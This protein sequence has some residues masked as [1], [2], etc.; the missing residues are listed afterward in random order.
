LRWD[1]D[2][3]DGPH[4]NEEFELTRHLAIKDLRRRAF[5]VK[6]ALIHKAEQRLPGSMSK[7]FASTVVSCLAYLDPKNTKVEY[8]EE[9]E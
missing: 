6:K 4:P 9:G 2:S 7:M 5:E 1:D 8:Q 3:D